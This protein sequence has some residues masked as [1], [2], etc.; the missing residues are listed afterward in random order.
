[1]VQQEKIKQTRNAKK[2]STFSAAA[3]SLSLA[4]SQLTD[5]AP[6]ASAAARAE[7]AARVRGEDPRKPPPTAKPTAKPTTAGPSPSKDQKWLGAVTDREG[8]AV[9]CPVCGTTFFCRGFATTRSVCGACSARVASTRVSSMDGAVQIWQRAIAQER[10]GGRVLRTPREAEQPAA[11]PKPPPEFDDELDRKL[12]GFVDRGKRRYRPYDRSK[13]HAKGWTSAAGDA[14]PAT[15]TL[16]QPAKRQSRSLPRL[17]PPP[18]TARA[19][20]PTAPDCRTA[21]PLPAVPT[22]RGAPAPEAKRPPATAPILVG[23]REARYA[24]RKARW[25]QK[26]SRSR[27]TII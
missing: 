1:M 9:N 10:G 19:P 8:V 22:A 12:A 5:G 27:L 24:L 23:D 2:Y 11:A 7:R 17:E 21:P 16:A 25:Q 14:P 15:P 20:P 3:W 26:A 13:D 18:A 4:A 6:M